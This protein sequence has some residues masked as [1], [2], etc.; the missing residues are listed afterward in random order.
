LSPVQSHFATRR[1]ELVDDPLHPAPARAGRRQSPYPQ[2]R[3]VPVSQPSDAPA[4]E[5]V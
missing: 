1:S 5:V 3:S 2:L 4:P